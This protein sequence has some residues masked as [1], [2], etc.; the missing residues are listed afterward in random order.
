MVGTRAAVAKALEKIKQLA[1]HPERGSTSNRGYMT[2]SATCVGS[3]HVTRVLPERRR[4]IMCCGDVGRRHLLSALHGVNVLPYLGA[5]TPAHG[6]PKS[7]RFLPR[8][9]SGLARLHSAVLAVVR[10]LGVCHVRVLCQNG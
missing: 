7:A 9:Y 8:D 6:D 10:W 3:R 2:V 4:R 1:S 5:G